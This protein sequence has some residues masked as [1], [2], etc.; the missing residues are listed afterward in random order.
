MDDRT[1]LERAAKTA[2]VEISPSDIRYWTWNPLE[3]WHDAMELAVK[4]ELTVLP[5]IARDGEGRSAIEG[6]DDVSAATRRA[7]VRCAAAAL[8]DAREG[9]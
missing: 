1:L 6:G 3:S 5:G 4:L 2:G 9:V 7:I 8:A